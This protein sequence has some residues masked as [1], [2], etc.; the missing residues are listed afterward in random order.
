MYVQ[1]Q[2][3]LDSLVNEYNDDDGGKATKSEN[4]DSTA[5]VT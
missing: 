1:I 5:Q 4:Q 2:E 3:N